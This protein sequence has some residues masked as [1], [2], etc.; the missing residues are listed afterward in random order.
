[1]S[2]PGLLL[3]IVTTALAIEVGLHLRHHGA[4]QETESALEW[5]LDAE[6]IVLSESASDVVTPSLFELPAEVESLPGGSYYKM[7][8]ELGLAVGRNE[9]AYNAEGVARP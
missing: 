1:M 8:Y 7:G 6:P 5:F 3:A 2:I 9:C 4:K